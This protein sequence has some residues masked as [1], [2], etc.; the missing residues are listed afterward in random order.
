MVKTI[1]VNALSVTNQSGLHVLAG[2]LDSLID[3]FRVTL[4]AR[5]SM[6]GL[7]DRFADRVD[8]IF[9]QENTARWLPR[10]LWE[11]QALEKIARTVAA[12]YY[13]TPSGIAASRLSIPQV[14]LCQNPWALVPSARRRR[15]APK[16][17][18]QRRA[19]RKTMRTAEVM[20]FNSKFMQEAY[21][22]NAGL[23]AGSPR[24]RPSAT[25]VCRA[26]AETPPT[27]GDGKIQN[28]LP[29]EIVV[30][31]AADEETRERSKH[32]KGRLRNLG[33]IVCVSAMAPHKNI[34]TLIR[35]IKKLKDGNAE[36]LKTEERNSE[37]GTCKT[38]KRQPSGFQDFRVSEFQ[39]RRSAFQN[40]SLH[41][42]GS[43]PD[44]IYESKILRL[45]ADL[46]LT[47]QVHFHGFVSREELDRLYAESQ[48]FCLMSRCESFG[49]PAIEAQL[50]GTPVV[51][52]NVCAVPEICGD[53]GLF[54]DPD[55]VDGVAEALRVL[56]EGSTD[57]KNK[58]VE[59]QPPSN[60]WKKYSELALRN[61]DRFRWET[62]SKPLVELFK[63]ELERGEETQSRK[64]AEP[65]RTLRS[66]APLR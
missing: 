17:W 25:N 16:A 52:S 8:W 35:A 1:L 46:G 42:V 23:P 37:R 55:D 33:Q 44:A 13:F 40:L 27:Q 65:K 66:P 10:S 36:T 22:R 29:S 5:E 3:A 26:G 53:G 19:Y 49:I 34:E 56:L 9:A 50:F 31:Q 41:L 32:W 39:T 64:G 28:H 47:E 15:D 21:R 48:I 24:S 2:H 20:V 11:F 61:A 43:W 6:S 45:V 58:G 62:C 54:C 57:W 7:R 51:C 30:Y 60:V 63:A 18:L 12:D 14:V 59:A 4:I 38:L